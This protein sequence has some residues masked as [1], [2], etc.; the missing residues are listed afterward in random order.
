MDNKEKKKQYYLD[1]K[2]K[3]NQRSRDY[4]NENRERI[5][6]QKKEFRK[7]NQ[8]KIR[9]YQLSPERMKTQTIRQWKLQD[10]IFFDYDLLY[11]IYINTTHCDK[12][13]VEFPNSRKLTA[14]SRCLDHDHSITEYDNVRN[15]LCFRCNSKLPK[16]N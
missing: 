5:N 2:E 7:N 16:Q 12:C 15:V 10:I 9:E 3:I 11:E 14:D 8:E 13:E 6:L 1:N 4:F